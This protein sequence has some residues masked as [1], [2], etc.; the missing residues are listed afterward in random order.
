MIQMWFAYCGQVRPN[1]QCC[2]KIKIRSKSNTSNVTL[3]NHSAKDTRNEWF[4][5]RS[6]A[7]KFETAAAVY[8]IVSAQKRLRKCEWVCVH[9]D[10]MASSIRSRPRVRN[11]LSRCKQKRRRRSGKRPKSEPMLNEVV[12]G[13][14]GGC[15]GQLAWGPNIVQKKEGVD[16]LTKRVIGQWASF[17]GKPMCKWTNRRSQTSSGKSKN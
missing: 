13:I 10:K 3:T 14:I 6:R 9:V 11:E 2:T 16:L 7:R 4:A 12:V 17:G 1:D 5:T 8:K 15:G